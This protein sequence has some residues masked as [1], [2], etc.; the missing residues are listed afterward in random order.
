MKCLDPVLRWT[1]Q[2][3]TFYRHFSHAS[4][5]M[6]HM[7]QLV[8]DCGKCIFC[9]KKKSY[10]LASRCVLHASLYKKNCFLTL[11]YDESLS[12]YHNNFNYKDIQDFKK[13]LRSYV[14]RKF[15]HRIELFNVHEYGKN[16]KKHW[17]LILFNH[18]FSDKTIFSRKNDRPLYTSEQLSKLWPHG[19][20][21]IGD[22]SE[23][24]AM[25]QA[26]YTQKDF[27]NGNTSNGKKSHSK[28]SG[29]GRPYF[30]KHYKQILTL[31]F[32]PFAGRKMPLPRYFEKLAHKHYCHFYDKS[33]FFDNS[34][35]KASYRPFK[36]GEENLEIADLF[37]QYKKMKQEKI[38]ELSADWD[39]VISQFI[40]TRQEPD[41]VKSAQNALYDL[42]NRNT[43]EKF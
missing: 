9:R 6:L 1:N 35:R 31:G 39:D 23:A 13:R 28:H 27:K 21:T 41:F 19:F 15:G 32:V 29:I 12:T 43:K 10:E 5:V 3:K 30:L 18:D 22:V 42:Q 17:H 7:H 34:E 14:S 4:P 37:V 2:N 8:F 16:G 24:S 20:C 38:D 40:D 26:Q 11:T 33:Y 36:L 25:Y